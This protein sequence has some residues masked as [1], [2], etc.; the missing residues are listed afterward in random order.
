MG[1]FPK[2]RDLTIAPERVEFRV[3]ATWYRRRTADL[4]VRI[5]H[6]L[7]DHLKWRSRSSVQVLVRDGYVLVDAATPNHPRGAGELRVERRPGRKLHHGSR[8]VVV[9]PDEFRIR[10]SE[11]TSDELDVLYEDAEVLA[12]DKPAGL[13]VHPGGRHLADTLIQRVHAR[14]RDEIAAGRLAPRLCH[15]LDR[16]TSGIV[17][18]GKR[19]RTHR[20]VMQQFEQ[21]RVEKEY[22]AIV[23][24][25]LAADRGT[26]DFPIAPSRMSPI[27]LKMAVLADGLPS[28]TD[29]VV[30]ERYAGYTLLRCVL[31]TG[32]QHQI[33]VHLA[34]LGNPLVGDKLYGPDERLFERE[35]DGE[36]DLADRRALELPRH[37]LHSHRLVFRTPASGARIEVTSPLAEDL[38]QFLET[39]HRALV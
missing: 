24:G 10:L 34:A 4:H 5:D 33:R 31:F 14:Y 11:A 7:A 20:A 19:P 1:I 28:R 29:W 35:I 6:F 39:K 16:E 36:L 22:L 32:R 37:A 25:E 17:L 18:I 27:R 30:V 26:V 3:D 12:V 15:R 21:H 38:A 13:A 2:D 8:V 23:R 9:I